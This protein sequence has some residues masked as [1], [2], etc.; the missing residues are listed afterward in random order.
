MYLIFNK[1]LIVSCSSDILFFKIEH[2]V[3]TDNREFQVYQSIRNVGQN[4]IYFNENNVRIQVVTADKIYFYKMNRE[5][6]EADL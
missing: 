1:A 3:E 6:L 2:S 4:S 5:T